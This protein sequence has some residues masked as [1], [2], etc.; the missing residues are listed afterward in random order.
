M[1]R[2]T[3]GDSIV[4]SFKYQNEFEFVPTFKLWLAANDAPRVRD[5][6]AAIWRRILRVPFDAQVPEGKRDKS[7]K[8]NPQ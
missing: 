6:D 3:G 2:I 5:D 4:A 1:K 8:A 7:V